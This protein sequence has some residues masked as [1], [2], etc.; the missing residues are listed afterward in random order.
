ML[1]QFTAILFFAILATPHVAGYIAYAGCTIA[2]VLNGDN[3]TSCDCEKVKDPLQNSPASQ[4]VKQKA[5]ENNFD[6]KYLQNKNNVSAIVV[7]ASSCKYYNKSDEKS[8]I[9]YIEPLFHPPGA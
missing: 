6:W 9:P 4:P 1:R 5:S 2:T 8:S 7:S 3:R